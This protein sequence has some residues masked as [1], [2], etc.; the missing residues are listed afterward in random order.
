[1]DEPVVSV[2]TN[3][4][5]TVVNTTKYVLEHYNSKEY[6][7][8][9]E[10]LPTPADFMGL[11]RDELIDYLTEYE[12]APSLEDRQLG[13]ESFELVSFSKD[14]IVLRKTYHPYADDYKYYLKDENGYVTVYYID[15][16]TI[17][18]YTNIAV[19]SLP[20][21]LQEELVTGKYMS[22]MNE[23]YNFLENYSS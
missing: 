13:F 21:D 17:Y 3:N 15:K 7:L 9:E 12:K 23:L 6:T 2:D 5:Q 14:Q 11:T 19:D 16:S 20:E 22:T 18:E 1:Q 4:E 10:T 8:N